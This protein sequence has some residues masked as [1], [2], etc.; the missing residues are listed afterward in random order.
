MSRAR[1]AVPSRASA[2]SP[3]SPVEQVDEVEED[4]RWMRRA[5]AL[6]RRGLG[7]TRPNPMVGAVVVRGGQLL[8][9]GF[10]RR[11]GT[12]HA[13]I[14]AMAGLG[15][16]AAGATLYVTLE[17]CCHTGRTAPCTT[18][19]IAA[20]LAR[21]VVGVRDP[22]PLVNGR[23]IAQLRRAGIRVDVATGNVAAACRELNRPFFTWI[24]QHRPLVTLKVAASLDGFIADGRAG[25]AAAPVWITGREARASAHELRSQHDA[26]LVGAGTVR[27]DNPRLTVRHHTG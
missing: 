7:A 1:G 27:A 17:P 24:Q 19:V 15:R 20:G 18:A 26:V 14:N 21:V 23:G 6:A 10:H 5:L 4:Q 13:E 22:N 25:R 3:G 12:P 2:V 8:G 16:R 9:Q 11:A